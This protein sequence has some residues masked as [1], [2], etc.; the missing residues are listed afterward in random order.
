MASVDVKEWLA[1]REAVASKLQTSGSKQQP[2][3]RRTIAERLLTSGY[4]DVPAVLADIAPEKTEIGDD[5]DDE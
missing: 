4:I 5:S 2:D 3:T 1:I